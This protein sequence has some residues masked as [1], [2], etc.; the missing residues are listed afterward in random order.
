METF[1][2][3]DS[4]WA[5]NAKA[6]GAITEVTFT[7]G[8]PV[9]WHPPELVG[10]NEALTF[11]GNVT[12]GSRYSLVALDQPTVVP[13][14]TSNRPVERLAG[15]LVSWNGGG[16]QSSNRGRL[17]M[18][19]DASPIWAFLSTLGATED[20]EASRTATEGLYLM[21]TYPAA[22]LPT[23]AARSFGR[24]LA[25]KYNPKPKSKFKP[26]DWIV[27]ATAASAEAQ[28]LRC[29][30]VAVWC[31]AA[32]NISHPMKGDQDKLDAVICLLAA[33]RWRLRPRT[34]SVML[35]DIE[36]GYMVIP[37]SADVRVYL[38]KAAR[39]KGVPM[40]GLVPE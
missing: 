36:T 40:D 20:P 22:A 33:V 18:F 29:D 3:F 39:R 5:G 24:M 6:P 15:S 34:D 37:A 35:G 8:A 28:S 4:A 38:M 27:V 26:D 23:L 11:I 1:I 32:A 12:S 2:G 7:G 14:L 17:G 9:R 21:E 16:T 19:C 31:A 30:D 13:N 10:F 25:L